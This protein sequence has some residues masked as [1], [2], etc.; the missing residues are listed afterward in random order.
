[1]VCQPSKHFSRIQSIWARP[2]CISLE[3]SISNRDVEIIVVFNLDKG[4]LGKTLWWQLNKGHHNVWPV[5]HTWVEPVKVLT[6]LLHETK[7]PGLRFLLKEGDLGLAVVGKTEARTAEGL[8][9]SVAK[10]DEGSMLPFK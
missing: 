8:A 6:S 1:M 3:V 2:S 10:L 9:A 5:P 7:S 4:F